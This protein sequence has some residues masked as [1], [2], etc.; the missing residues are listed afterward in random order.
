MWYWVFR[1]VIRV[2]LRL[3]FRL[4]VEGLENIPRKTNFIIVSNHVSFLDPVAVMA[5]V[6]RKIHCIAARYLYGIFWLRVFLWL[7]E[8][9]PTVGSAEKA[10]QLLVNNKIVGIFPEGG[11][12]RDGRLKEF[13]SGSALLALKTG[14]PILPCAILGTYAA[15]PLG[16]W[17]PKFVTV[18]V[19]IGRP[20]YLFIEP[21]HVIDELD[22]QDGVFKIR[23]VIQ[24]ML[25]AE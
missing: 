2:V 16:A 10:R 14:R 8:A 6:P 12:S 21:D 7:V 20:K 9:T 25:Y 19:K 17:F 23:S 4:K 1:A 13:R 15:L 11:I 3:L 24:E 22:L 5:A 18:R